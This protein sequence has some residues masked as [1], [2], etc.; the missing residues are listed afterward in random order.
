M[1]T[2]A[3]KVTHTHR[4]EAQPSSLCRRAMHAHA[5]KEKERGGKARGRSRCQHLCREAL[6]FVQLRGS[7]HARTRDLSISRKDK[8]RAG[9]T[10]RG[11]RLTVPSPP[12]NHKLTHHLPS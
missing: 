2:F 7:G 3:H 1:S 8:R 5:K 11:A 4:S 9:G 12:D 6:P 10:G